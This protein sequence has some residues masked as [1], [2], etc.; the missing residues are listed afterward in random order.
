MERLDSGWADPVPLPG[1]VNQ[2]MEA[3]DDWPSAYESGAVTDA[4]GRLYYWSGS[5]RKRGSDIFRAV[6]NE[7]GAYGSITTPVEFSD[8]VCF[9]SYPRLSPDGQL[10]FFSSSERAGGLG[11]EDIYYAKK[12]NG[13]WSRPRNLGPTVNSGRN[14]SFPAFS[15]DGRYFFFSSDR[16]PER[17]AAGEPI[18]T[19][20]YME[21]RFLLLM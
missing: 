4:D 15:P 7:G 2:T 18:W 3:S 6:P 20:Y 1:E 9:D 13:R 17:D 12:V 19:I 8:Y 14:D 16:G 5:T 11:G 21:T 10:L